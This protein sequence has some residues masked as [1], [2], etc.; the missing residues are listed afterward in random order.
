MHAIITMI[1]NLLDRFFFLILV[2]FSAGKSEREGMIER[3]DKEF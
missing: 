2:L 1:M 3:N